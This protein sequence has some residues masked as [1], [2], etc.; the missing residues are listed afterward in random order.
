MC[1]QRVPSL[2]V[3]LYRGGRGEG[4]TT[5]DTHTTYTHTTGWEA[6]E[7]RDARGGSREA[8]V[9]PRLG[10][11]IVYQCARRLAT[12]TPWRGNRLQLSQHAWPNVGVC[13]DGCYRQIGFSLLSPSLFLCLFSLSVPR[14]LCLVYK[15]R[16]RINCSLAGADDC[17]VD[18]CYR[19][20]YFE[21]TRDL[22]SRLKF[23][24]CYLVEGIL[25]RLF[26]GNRNV[27]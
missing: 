27:M 23:R 5:Q 11:R 4:N 22:K 1:A 3:H 21:T 20:E 25:S 24:Y 13:N 26:C 16:G 17:Q 19:I 2:G 18:S 12:R 9:E 15:R 7:T 10:F 8:R 6:E 14:L